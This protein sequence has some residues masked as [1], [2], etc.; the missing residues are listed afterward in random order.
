MAISDVLNSSKLGLFAS[1]GAMKVISH[2]IANVNT[3]G[4]SRQTVALSA[5]PG[6]VMS[7]KPTAS[8]D[9]VQIARVGHQVDELLENRLRMGSGDIGRLSARDRFMKII[10]D[11]FNEFDKDGFSTRLSAFFDAVDDAATNP[12]NSAARIQVVSQA[13]SLSNT[14]NQMYRT[15]NDIDVPIDQEITGVVNDINTKIKSLRDI[16]AMVVR[17]NA[18]NKGDVALD[19]IDQRTTLLKELNDLIDI[20]PIEQ[21]DGGVMVVTSGGQLL[22]DHDYAVQL[23]R[24]KGSVKPTS[25]VVDGNDN[26]DITR[27]IRSGTLKGLLEIRDEVLGGDQGFIAYFNK[28]TDELRRQVNQVYS[29]SVG[30]TMNQKLTGTVY[31]DSDR[32]TT[33][34]L[35]EL[36]S[37][38]QAGKIVLAYGPDDRHL[39]SAT[40]EVTNDMTLDSLSV[41]INDIAGLTASVINGRL[42]IEGEENSRFAVASDSSR[43]LAALGVG[44]LFSGSG[45]VDMAVNPELLV[46]KGGDPARLATARIQVASNGTVTFDDAN[47]GGMVALAALRNEKINLF[48][49]RATFTAHYATLVSH[50]GSIQQRN[51]DALTTQQTAQ[52]FLSDARESTSGVSLDEELTD[53]V[54]FQRS[55]QASS[56][57]ITVADELFKSILSMGV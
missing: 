45:S 31:V 20:Q 28:L 38:V 5:N 17:Q 36:A 56:R 27:Q 54:K 26:T 51:Q 48:G 4:Y 44:T 11:N 6:I 2:N 23:S 16:N 33:A 30:H 50:V 9:G 8:G 57:M 10:E 3:A 39:Q 41:A 12:T 1:Q 22:M 32:V 19:L 21:Q 47:N 15:L 29:Q 7:G 40:I 37:S 35:T 18:G 52:Q 46:E 43:A 55:F 53:M 42:V 24:G 34:P 49:E 14:V 25:I 13:Q